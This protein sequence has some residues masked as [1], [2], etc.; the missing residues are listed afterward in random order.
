MPQILIP[1]E[2]RDYLPKE[3]T[4]ITLQELIDVCEK[5]AITLNIDVNQTHLS[6]TMSQN[7]LSLHRRCRDVW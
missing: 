4:K 5:R 3:I 7:N 6:F 1:L 2:L